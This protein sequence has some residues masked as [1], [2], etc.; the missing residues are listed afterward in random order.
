M[1]YWVTASATSAA[2]MYYESG[3]WR[4]RGPTPAPGFIEVPTGLAVFPEELSFSPRAWQE[5]HYNLVRWTE[6]PRGGHFAAMEQPE[7]FVDDVRAFYA[8]LRQ[9]ER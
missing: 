7:L 2:R 3:R 8:D 6:M 1:L 4:T 5:A 9:G